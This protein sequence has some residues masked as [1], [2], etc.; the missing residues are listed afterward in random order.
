MIPAQPG[1][2][3]TYQFGD[4]RDRAELVAW[5]DRGWPMVF[6]DKELAVINPE[7]VIVI[8]RNDRDPYPEFTQFIPADDLRVLYRDDDDTLFDHPAIG[9]GVTRTGDIVPVTIDGDWTI[10]GAGL[11]DYETAFYEKDREAT[12]AAYATKDR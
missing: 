2:Y 10:N 4:G 1:M 8:D 7:R 5:N 9:W 11:S 12:Y 6:A 3:V